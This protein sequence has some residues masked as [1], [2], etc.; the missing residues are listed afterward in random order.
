[1]ILLVEKSHTLEYGAQWVHGVE[2]NISYQMASNRNL[3]EVNVTDG[4][5]SK[6]NFFEVVIGPEIWDF[7]LFYHLDIKFLV[8]DPSFEV[9]IQQMFELVDNIYKSLDNVENPEQ[10]THGNFFNRVF[11]DLIKVKFAFELFVINLHF[12]RILLFIRE[13]MTIFRSRQLFS[14]IFIIALS[15]VSR[16]VQIGMTS[17]FRAHLFDIKSVLELLAFLSKAIENTLT[18]STSLLKTS[19]LML[20]AW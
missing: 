3:L 16:V 6:K 20:F 14:R 15:I 4:F 13:R 12:Q 9:G 19:R 11:F 1:M 8:D 5:D 2:D 7:S 10:E 17:A 18:C